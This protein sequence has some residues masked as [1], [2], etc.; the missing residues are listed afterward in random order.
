M[1]RFGALSGV[2]LALSIGVPGT[3]EAVTGET[4]VTSAAL[5]LGTAFGAP[6]VSALYFHQAPAAGRLGAVGYAVNLVGLALFSGVAFAL[7]LVV[8]FQG[9]DVLPA[10]SRV[11]VLGSVVVFVVGSLLFSASMV[12]AGV[13][14]RLAAYGYGLFLPLLAF[15]SRLPDGVWTS[16]VHVLAAASLA[17]LSLA[18]WPKAGSTARPE[19]VR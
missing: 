4:A 9:S 5:G 2:L 3:I 14:P 12:R 8:F 7:N 16:A 6:A 17:R 15:A 18:V 11:A 19:Q 1:Q 13:L 10:P